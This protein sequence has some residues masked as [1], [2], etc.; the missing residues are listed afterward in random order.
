MHR[1]KILRALVSVFI[2]LP[3]SGGAATKV[4]VFKEF[5]AKIQLLEKNLAQ[6][7]NINKRY[8]AFLKTFKELS[9]LRK[10]NPRQEE[11][12]EISMSFFMDALAP[13][14][15]KTEFQA[16]KCAEY[17]QQ[18]ESAAKAY[19]ESQKDEFSTRAVK[20]TKLICR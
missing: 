19:E 9:E 1:I 18:V 16:K 11:D 15:G 7:K 12:K 2:A 14:P 10:E 5:N 20:I 3:L 6:E 17:L 8:D 13:L 4:D